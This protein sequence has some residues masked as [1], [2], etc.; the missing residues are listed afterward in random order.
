VVFVT[1]RHAQREQLRVEHLKHDAQFLQS[2]P[3]QK[4]GVVAS[5]ITRQHRM[6]L[7]SLGGGLGH[8]AECASNVKGWNK[9]LAG[10]Q[11]LPYVFTV[12]SLR[13]PAVTR[14]CRSFANTINASETGL[15]HRPLAG[16]ET[17][18]YEVI[19]QNSR[20]GS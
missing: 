10:R 18:A 7:D 20:D 9:E 17:N 16:R 6:L 4:H 1:I 14:T 2:P 13:S 11:S 15:A 5:R 12:T 19:F 3:V 8:A